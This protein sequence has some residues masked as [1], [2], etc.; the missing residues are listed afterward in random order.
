MQ[1]ACINA[2]SAAGCR[3]PETRPGQWRRSAETRLEGREQSGVARFARG[4]GY[5]WSGSWLLGLLL[6]A[7]VPCSAALYPFKTIPIGSSAS[8]VAIGD[9]NGDGRADVAVATRS[10]GDPLNDQSVFVFLQTAQGTLA[11]PV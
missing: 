6:L 9:L 2:R 10:G 11:T 5:P 3:R 4:V 8:V 7:A 1:T